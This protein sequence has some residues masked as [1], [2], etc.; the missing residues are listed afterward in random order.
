MKPITNREELRSYL[1]EACEIEQQ[2]MIQYL[3]A[4]FTMKKHPDSS[5]SPAQ[6]EAV[7]RWGS[8]V[9]MVARQ[10]MEH[11]ALANGILTAIAE[12]PFFARENIPLQS[13]YYLGQE[14]ASRRSPNEKVTPCDIPFVFE[15]FN[16]DTIGRFVCAESPGYATLKKAGMRIPEWCFGT[17]NH[18]CRSTT[19]A[20]WLGHAG[21]GQESL[22][23]V[24]NGAPQRLARTHLQ[25][26]FRAATPDTAETLSKPLHPGSIQE[27]YDNINQAIHRIPNLFV[28]NP[29]QQVFVP[30]EYQINVVP[31][32]DV[33]SADLAIRLIVEEG[34]GIEAPP[35]YQS[36]FTRF[37]DVRDQYVRLLQE[38]KGFDPALPVVTN[39][40]PDV[41]SKKYT[42]RVFDLF[43]HAYVTLLFLL[44][45]L[46]RNFSAT[47]S[48]YPFFSAALQN[49]AF[50]PFMTMIL[51]PIAEVLAHL[52]VGKDS[53]E[54]A[55]P[56]FYLS[57]EDEILLWPRPPAPQ[58][59]PG[60]I[61]P[62]EQ[63]ALAKQLDD[64]EFFLRRLDYIVDELAAL[65]TERKLDNHLIDSNHKEWA[66]RQLAFVSE[67]AQ[68]MANNMRRIYQVG[69][70]QQFVVQP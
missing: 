36:H 13:R 31:I 44:T 9:L 22:R 56:S 12:D 2:L 37:F 49:A 25:E 53:R 14:L 50:G 41:I 34:E 38:H 26:P 23:V 47:E 48:S 18:K 16:L 32:T 54:T 45:S 15:R 19:L 66:R 51:R 6:L 67:S 35:G 8:Q 52:K 61:E 70:I 69:E 20:D 58:T 10:E 7:R 62:G 30:V 46:Y 33:A 17:K 27:L 43:N 55:G 63:V 57:R 39:P 29:N 4:A 68:A 3:F 28:G 64:I 24:G 21:N 60:E 42:L 59:S 65:S 1:W 11:L 5:C 40:S